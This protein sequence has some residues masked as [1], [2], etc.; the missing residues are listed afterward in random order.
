MD[1][2]NTQIAFLLTIIAGL[3]TGIGG[4]I[5]YFIKK[6]KFSTLSVLMGFSA[7]IIIYT[8]FVELLS[9]SIEG[10]GFIGANLAFLAAIIA[11]F[12]LDRLVPH[13]HIDTRMDTYGDSKSSQETL[14]NSKLMKSAIFIAIGI[15]FHNFP[16][17]MSVLA[18]SLKD[19][20]TGIPIAFAIALHNIP[21]GIAVS[22]PVF[23]VTKNRLKAFIYSLLSGIT[24]PVGALIGFLLLSNFLTPTVL[25]SILAVVAGIMVFISFDELLPIA[26]DYG[27]EHLS[28][29]GLFSGMALMMLSLI[30]L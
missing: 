22:V 30:L 28:N 1:I 4:L 29:I 19:I 17:G 6:P 23:Y 12:I 27:N 13:T 15:T 5:T 25:N 26:K 24:E 18:A 16:E 20:S 7:G 10:I 21:E 9:E 8:S 2:D 11:M 3:S 14:R